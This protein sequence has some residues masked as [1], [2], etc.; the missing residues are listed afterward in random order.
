MALDI[1]D[2]A[3]WVTFLIKKRRND[4]SSAR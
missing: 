3:D 1:N 4:I 2:Y